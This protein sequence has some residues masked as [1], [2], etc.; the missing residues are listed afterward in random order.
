MCVYVYM[1]MPTKSL[2]HHLELVNVF[3]VDRLH[4]LQLLVLRPKLEKLVAERVAHHLGEQNLRR[5]LPLLIV[6]INS[7]SN[8]NSDRKSTEVTVIEFMQNPG[9][10]DGLH[11]LLLF[12]VLG[13]HQCGVAVRRDVPC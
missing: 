13:G 10:P 3:A 5:S 8:A 6:V 7:D 12:L 2:D 9:L 11:G 4:C 1:Y